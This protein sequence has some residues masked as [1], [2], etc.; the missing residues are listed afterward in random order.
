MG[1]RSHYDVLGVSRR[2][3]AD[4]VRTAYRRAARD[5]H[6][7]A[8]GDPGRMSD[9]NAAW[10]VLGDP[11]RRAAYDRQLARPAAGVAD[12]GLGDTADGGAGRPMGGAWDTTSGVYRT[13]DEWADLVDDEPLRPTRS[14]EGWWAL[15]PPA[16]LVS[17]LACVF[18]SFIFMAPDLLALAGGL[19]VLSFGL[20]VLAPLRAMSRKD[21]D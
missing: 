12:P 10:H 8:G 9:L 19:F 17:A 16:T 20:F 21:P 6:P 2:A 14:L 4:E 7:D 18:A 5:H 13:A 11:V 3:S 1:E 15:V